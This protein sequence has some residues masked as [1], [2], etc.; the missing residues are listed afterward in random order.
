ML[1]STGSQEK[2]SQLTQLIA[3]TDSTIATLNGLCTQLSDAYTGYNLGSLTYD[4]ILAS[5]SPNKMDLYQVKY[6]YENSYAT[7][8]QL[9]GLLNLNKTALQS[10]LDTLNA[11]S[12]L[13]SALPQIQQLKQGT[14]QLVGGVDALKEGVNLLSSKMNELSAGTRELKEGMTTLN[15]GIET[16]NREGVQ[17][18]SKVTSTMNRLSNKVESLAKLSNEYQTFDAKNNEVEGNTKFVLVVDSVKAPKKE[19]KI[20]KEEKKETVLDRIKNLFK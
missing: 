13:T 8:Q 20:V 7:Y 6:N 9:I 12:E 15:T 10:S 5:T 2:I 3:G 4:Q 17:K 14:T 18:L 1:D 19:K 11:S 16:F